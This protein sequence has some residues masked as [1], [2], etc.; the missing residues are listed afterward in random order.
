MKGEQREHSANV[1]Y[2]LDGGALLHRIPWPRG[3][4]FDSV[5]VKCTLR[6][7]HR[8][9]ELL[10]LSLMGTHISPQLKMPHN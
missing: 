3:S 5:C 4:K 10:S 9:M 2:V 6:M 8:S 7:S 1:Q